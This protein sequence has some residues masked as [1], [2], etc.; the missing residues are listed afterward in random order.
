VFKQS[1]KSVRPGLDYLATI[2]AQQRIVIPG[3]RLGGASEDFDEM[4]TF[5]GA[6]LSP[7]VGNADTIME[8]LEEVEFGRPIKTRLVAFANVSAAPIRMQIG[9]DE[10]VYFDLYVTLSPTEESP[11]ETVYR[12][13]DGQSGVFESEISLSPLFELRPLGR[14]GESIFID[15]GRTPLPGFPM[16]LG[17]T[18]G[19]WSRTPLTERAVRSFGGESLFYSNEVLIKAFDAD[20]KST[21]AACAKRQAEFSLSGATLEF[22]RVNF[23][24]PREYTNIEL[25][26]WKRD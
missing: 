11:G 12:S 18:G 20:G 8:R 4:V 13:Q 26:R 10:P 14:K 7:P 15:T 3:E 5:V 25:R 19:T 16:R 22:E 1:A 9:D 24:N 2:V 21:L 17:S 6:P 23:P